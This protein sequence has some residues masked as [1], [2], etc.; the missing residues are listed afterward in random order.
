MENKYVTFCPPLTKARLKLSSK[1]ERE[2]RQ[3][4]SSNSNLKCVCHQMEF[5]LIPPDYKLNAK[6]AYFNYRV[7]FFLNYEMWKF[8]R[9]NALIKN[10]LDKFLTYIVRNFNN[11]REF[12]L[13][14]LY[15]RNHISL[16]K[17]QI[18]FIIDIIS[19]LHMRKVNSG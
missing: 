19:L 1:S 2:E 9:L 13:K 8:D 7:Q 10:P 4:Q 15:F 17:N 12:F 16:L 14:Y 3:L 11:R 18:L 6:A 5:R